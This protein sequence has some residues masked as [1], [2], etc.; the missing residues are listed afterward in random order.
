MEDITI[1][2]LVQ[3]HMNSGGPIWDS[4]EGLERSVRSYDVISIPQWV[5]GQVNNICQVKDNDLGQ[6]YL[7]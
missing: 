7:K 2:K 5:A 1:R 6:F 3:H 4:F